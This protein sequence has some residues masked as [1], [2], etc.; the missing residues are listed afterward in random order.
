MTFNGCTV[1][2]EAEEIIRVRRCSLETA[3]KAVDAAREF[4]SSASNAITNVCGEASFNVGGTIDIPCECM[5]GLRNGYT[6][7]PFHRDE[8]AVRFL[9]KLH[10]LGLV[11]GALPDQLAEQVEEYEAPTEYGWAPDLISVDLKTGTIVKSYYD[12]DGRWDDMYV[13]EVDE[14]LSCCVEWERDELPTEPPKGL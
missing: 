3:K 4:L 13:G 6:W 5:W 12:G 2:T 11:Y 14:M 7:A 1:V 9:Q 10:E 8:R